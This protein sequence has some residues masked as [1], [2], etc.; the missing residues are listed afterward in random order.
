MGNEQFIKRL[1][2]EVRN[3]NRVTISFDGRLRI[4]DDTDPRVAEIPYEMLIGTYD[5]R[6]NT[7]DIEEDCIWA[8]EQIME[9]ERIT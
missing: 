3:G 7:K 8:I 2:K 5:S 1:Q 6:A 4:M 9:T